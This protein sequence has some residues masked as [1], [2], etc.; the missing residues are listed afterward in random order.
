MTREETQNLLAMIQAT[1]PNFNP[2]D[3]TAA[4]NAWHMA[5]SD[6]D[7]KEIQRAFAVYMR[8]N[9]SGFAPSPGQ[10]VEKMVMLTVPQEMNELEAWG[11]V[12]KAL[13]NSTYNSAEEF[14]KLPKLCQKAIGRPEQLRL[15]A[16]DED[17]NEG[18]ASSNFMRSYRNAKGRTEEL[19]RMPEKIRTFIEN[20]NQGAQAA[21]IGAENV[22]AIETWHEE[23]KQG[24]DHP[25]YKQGIPDE[26]LK[27]LRTILKR[28]D[29]AQ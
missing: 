16:I 29:E 25:E 13:R 8:T 10:V 19:N 5:L 20:L 17:Y 21:G 6:C 23:R 2:P 22:Q 9:T 28:E 3:K 26:A 4:V 7:W 27:K 11:L 24:H 12:S 15:W 14:K 18:V 1:Y